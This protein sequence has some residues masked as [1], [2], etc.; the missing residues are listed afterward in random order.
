MNRRTYVLLI[1]GDS[2]QTETLASALRERGHA[3][4]IAA[5][6]AEGM[7]QLKRYPVRL[8]L[9]DLEL[10]DRGGLDILS[11][12][13]SDYPAIESIVFTGTS[14]LESAIEATN[15]GAFSILPKPV[16]IEPLLLQIRRAMERQRAQEMLYRDSLE[17]RKINME[18]QALYRVSQAISQTLELDEL[19][20]RVLQA[21]TEIEIF[22]F[23]VRGAIFLFDQDNLRLASYLSLTQ[24]ELE[25]CRE[26]HHGECL[27]GKALSSGEIVVAPMQ[28]ETSRNLRCASCDT[29]AHGHIIVPLKAAQKVVGLLNLFIDPDIDVEEEAI[30]LLASLG[31][32]IGIAINNALLYEELRVS[33][34]HDPLTGLANRRFLDNQLTKNF[35]RAKRYGG[36]LSVIMLDVDSFKEYND[37]FGHL[38]GD[39]LLTRVATLL[40]QEV[41]LADSV[42]R[43]GGE[44]FLILLPMTDEN[45]AI[46][47]AQRLRRVV[48]ADSAGVTISLGVAALT[49]TMQRQEDLVGA[50]DAALYRAKESGKNKVE[51]A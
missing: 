21:L 40:K 19:L 3:P 32:Q 42:F 50:A 8:I 35:A 31:N 17:L 28:H 18:L 11:T 38:Q 30:R 23:K 10:P 49:S 22:P 4:L 46:E 29:H 24:T 51:R 16:A 26:I 1:S 36:N 43:Y 27:C 44:E 48:A 6:A 45:E 14:G 39:W 20:T 25:P 9:L 34:L 2:A 7:A 13:T 12:I 37:T 15:R 33:A 47:T 41:R 5:T